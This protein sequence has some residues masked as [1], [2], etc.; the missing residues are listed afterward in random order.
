VHG[1]E[2]IEPHLRFRKG[3]EA[4]RNIGE[5]LKNGSSGDADEWKLGTEWLG[6]KTG[7]RSFQ[8]IDIEFARLLY[9][10]FMQKLVEGVGLVPELRPEGSGWRVT[11]GS[12]DRGFLAAALVLQLMEQLGGGPLRKC[13]ECLSWFQPRRRQVYCSKCGV[14]AAWRAAQRRKRSA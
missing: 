3:L 13:L 2:P 6:I 10:R 11:F 14:R 5:T 12:G 4:L 7:V 8:R 1:A 9:Q